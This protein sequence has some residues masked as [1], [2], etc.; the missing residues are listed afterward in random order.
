MDTHAVDP[1]KPDAMIARAVGDL[2]AGCGGVT[3]SLGHRLG[4]YKAM[5]GA[6]PLTPARSRAGPGRLRRALVRE[7]LDAQV[8][9]GYVP[10]HG[11]SGTYELTRYASEAYCTPRSE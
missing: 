7:W 5:A 4:V 3:V 1:V 8:A 2:S 6:G 11:V 9:G 10:C